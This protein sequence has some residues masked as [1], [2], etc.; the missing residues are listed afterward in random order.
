MAKIPETDKLG[1][2]ALELT[3]E[4]DTLANRLAHLK[5]RLMIYVDA[6]SA[7]GVDVRGLMP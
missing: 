7:R 2:E 5:E 6:L 3:K 4:M 1:A